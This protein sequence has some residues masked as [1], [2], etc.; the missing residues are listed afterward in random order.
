MKKVSE[1]GISKLLD[2]NVYDIQCFLKNRH[3]LLMIDK[4]DEI[5]EGQS[6]K[7]FKNFT[8][9]E[10][11]FPGHFEDNPIVPGVVT[12]EV[13]M[14]VFIMSFITMPEC[15][16]KETADL[17]VN[18]L[19]FI[20]QI[21][22]GDRLDVSAVLKSF[23]FGIATGASVGCV[24]GIEVCKCDLV[25]CVPDILNQYKPKLK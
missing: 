13:L 17:K 2:L 25:I 10:W 14:E 23:R 8:Y 16:G 20:K 5:V 24:D 22:P 11:F 18:N 15:A 19:E 6:A 9:N 7:G 3:P 12:L 4:V 21:V 1:N